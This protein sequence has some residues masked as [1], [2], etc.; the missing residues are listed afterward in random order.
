[1]QPI[2]VFLTSV[3]MLCECDLVVVLHFL[4]LCRLV[5]IMIFIPNYQFYFH[6]LFWLS[7]IS[8]NH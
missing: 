5:Q 7:N 3:D 1:M 6:I 2:E 4:Q 8:T